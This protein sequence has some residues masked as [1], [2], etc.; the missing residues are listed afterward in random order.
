MAHTISDGTTVITPRHI[1]GFESSRPTKT[2]V[3]T[4]VGSAAS[5]ITLRPAG[6]RT[7]T[8]EAIFDT[9]TQAL[10]LEALLAQAKSFALTVSDAPALGMAFVAVGNITADLDPDTDLWV[11]TSGFQEVA[12]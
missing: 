8:L 10:A 3:H 9:L 5:A 4:V 6:L 1:T 11:V 7:G 12:P 2:V